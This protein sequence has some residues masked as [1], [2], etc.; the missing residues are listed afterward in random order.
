MVDLMSNIPGE[1]PEKFFEWKSEKPLVLLD[2][3]GTVCEFR[4]ENE[5]YIDAKGCPRA[6]HFEDMYE[7]NYFSSLAP[8]VSMI[9][10]VKELI[11]AYGDKVEFG[12]L[13]AVLT[14]APYAAADKMKWIKEFL[15]EIPDDNIVF[16]GC[17]TDKGAQIINKTAPVFLID[18]YTK[19]LVNFCKTANTEHGT[20]YGIKVYNGINNTRGTWKGLAVDIRD[21]IV[22]AKDIVNKLSDAIMKTLTVNKH[23][24]YQEERQDNA[25]TESQIQQ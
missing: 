11:D 6:W 2:L 8:H 25:G 14:D 15:P 19:N 18:D 10:A 16:V 20:K 4:Q 1:A 24:T 7:A 17:G 21:G 23:I 12:V 3:D 9:E 13:T 5:I 22:T